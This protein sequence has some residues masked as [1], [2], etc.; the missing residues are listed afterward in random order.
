MKKLA[1]MALLGAVG[2]SLLA[3]VPMALANCGGAHKVKTASETPKPAP[4][5]V[6]TQS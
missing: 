5:T 6:K 1:M 3:P 4:A 2:F